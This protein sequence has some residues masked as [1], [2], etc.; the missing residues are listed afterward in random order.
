MRDKNNNFN[1]KSKFYKQSKPEIVQKYD[2]NGSWV[3]SNQ[4]QQ[5]PMQGV[6]KIEQSIV[7]LIEEL[8]EIPRNED[9]REFN[10]DL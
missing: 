7:P 3:S 9:D 2:E 5:K 8:K 1:A 4:T 10:G 6:Q